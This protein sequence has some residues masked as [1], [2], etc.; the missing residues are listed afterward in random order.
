[1]KASP[2][3][4]ENRTSFLATGSLG[5]EMVKATREFLPSSPGTADAI[6]GVRIDRARAGEPTGEMAPPATL[7]LD[8]LGE[9][10]S[11][12]HAGARLYEA[13]ISK[14]EA[15]GSFA[16]GPRAQ[17]LLHILQEEYEHADLLQQAIKGLGGDPT[18]LTPAANLAAS[19]SIGLPQVL[20]DPRTNLLQCLEAI[21]VAELSDNECW[22]ALSMLA[23]QGGRDELADQCRQAIQHEREHLQNVRRWIAAGQGRDP[24]VEAGA[25]LPED[26]E[27]EF[28]FTAD[29][30]VD[31]EG[32]AVSAEEAAEDR[33]KRPPGRS[34]TPGKGRAARRNR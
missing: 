28:T 20:A 11:F 6:A 12:E 10:L 2:N 25:P 9:R 31:R 32:F 13:L 30:P 1:M 18:V 23:R 19:I 14:H 24:S 8:K 22:S 5:E 27:D 7:L 17:D 33:A 16:G 4:G 26:E 3:R 34:R 29:S 21:V 15:Y